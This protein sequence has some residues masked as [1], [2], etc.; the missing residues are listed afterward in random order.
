MYLLILGVW[1][2]SFLYCSQAIFNAAIQV[3]NLTD[4]LNSSHHFL[5]VYDGNQLQT[6]PKHE[7]HDI[8]PE[9]KSEIAEKSV[10]RRQTGKYQKKTFI[11]DARDII[12]IIQLYYPYSL[13]YMEQYRYPRQHFASF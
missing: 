9:S 5:S 1:Y 10:I 3:I 6:Y 12:Q 8:I 2:M 13:A 7:I 4:L 11:N